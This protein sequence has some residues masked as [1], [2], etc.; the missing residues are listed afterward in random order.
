MGEGDHL[1]VRKDALET[2][3][4]RG[5]R[6][7]RRIQSQGVGELREVD[8]AVVA[9]EEATVACELGAVASAEERDELFRPAAGGIDAKQP[10]GRDPRD[11]QRAVGA[12]DRPLAEGR[13]VRDDFV[14]HLQRMAQ[15]SGRCCFDFERRPVRGRPRPALC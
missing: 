1:A 10:A 11:D 3:R 12:P 8:A 14:S 6:D 9:D 13:R 7:L 2:G 15:R 5:V 4:A